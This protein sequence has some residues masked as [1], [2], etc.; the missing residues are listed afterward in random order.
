MQMNETQMKV[1]AALM[2][3]YLD[4]VLEHAALLTKL[5]WN[6]VPRISEARSVLV[7]KL[8]RLARDPSTRSLLL[9][10]RPGARRNFVL[11]TAANELPKSSQDVTDAMLELPLNT[12]RQSVPIWMQEKLHVR[13]GIETGQIQS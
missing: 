4:A 1:D 8:Y 9:A 10:L 3:E 11:P 7:N 12:D 13:E 2:R 5:E 6:K